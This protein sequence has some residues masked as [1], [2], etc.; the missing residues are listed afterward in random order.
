LDAPVVIVSIKIHYTLSHFGQI[1]IS[2]EW[3]MIAL[4]PIVSNLGGIRWAVPAGESSF[5]FVPCQPFLCLSIVLMS[6]NWCKWEKR[7]SSMLTLQYHIAELLHDHVV[8]RTGNAQILS[9]ISGVRPS[10][11]HT[12]TDAHLLNKIVIGSAQIH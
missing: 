6:S 4:I 10:W 8:S 11:N 2:V 7:L 9:N 12:P 1:K 5:I 3:L